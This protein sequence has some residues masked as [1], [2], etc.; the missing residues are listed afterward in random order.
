MMKSAITA[1]IIAVF[2]FFTSAYIALKMGALPWPIIFSIIV[3][4]G[5]LR[6]VNDL[7]PNKVNIAQAGGSIGGFIALRVSKNGPEQVLTAIV[8]SAAVL[9]GEGTIGFLQS[10]VQVF[11]PAKETVILG[12]TALLLIA[13]LARSIRGHFQKP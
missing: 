9:G 12:L 4:A 8:I 2:L 5:L 13:L 6:L 1:V 3:S 10:T 7:S 11:F